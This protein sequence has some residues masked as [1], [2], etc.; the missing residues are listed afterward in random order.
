M[1]FRQC[2]ECGQEVEAAYWP[3]RCE[4]CTVEQWIALRI[5]GDPPRHVREQLPHLETIWT[6]SMNRFPSD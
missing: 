5:P 1:T 4:D 2:P 3:G 6:S